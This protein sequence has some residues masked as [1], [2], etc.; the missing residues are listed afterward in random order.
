MQA[1]KPAQMPS[2]DSPYNINVWLLC[3]R[4][5]NRIYVMG[6]CISGAGAGTAAVFSV[7]AK[8]N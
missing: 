4:C 8:K 7:D 6:E 3:Q 2:P 5:N 1:S